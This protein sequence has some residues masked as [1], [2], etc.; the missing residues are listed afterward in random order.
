MEVDIRRKSESDLLESERKLSTLIAN[1]PGVT[2]RCAC[3]EQWTMDFFQ[4]G[5]RKNKRVSCV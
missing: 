1:I 3:D 2:Y 5:N 4:Q